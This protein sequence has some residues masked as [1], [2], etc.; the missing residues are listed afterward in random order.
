M[1]DQRVQAYPRL[2]WGSET[3]ERFDLVLK[4]CRLRR[5]RVGWG[6]DKDFIWGV[7][8]RDKERGQELHF[9]AGT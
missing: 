4:P 6:L 1:G 7:L 9:E 3:G 5:L 8:V 2:W